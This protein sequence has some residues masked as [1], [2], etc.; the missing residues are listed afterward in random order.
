[1]PG[2]QSPDDSIVDESEA[3]IKVLTAL[4][5]SQRF[6]VPENVL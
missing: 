1:M 4:I 3:Q 2:S 6:R 5:V